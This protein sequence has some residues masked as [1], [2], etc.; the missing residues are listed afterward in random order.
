[1]KLLSKLSFYY[2]IL[3]ATNGSSGGPLPNM[4][5]YYLTK[6]DKQISFWNDID[7]NFR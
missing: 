1:M 2:K 7:I 4:D 5:Q 3:K 6:Q